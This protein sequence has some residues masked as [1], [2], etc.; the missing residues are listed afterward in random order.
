[1]GKD[2]TRPH[3]VKGKSR[4]RQDKAFRSALTWV[5]AGTG[6]VVLLLALVALGLGAAVVAARFLAPPEPYIDLTQYVE[7][8]E[9]AKTDGAEDR[10]LR[11]AVATMVSAEETFSTYRTLVER[12]G[13]DVG[14]TEAFI[15]RPSYADVREDLARGDLD[16]ALVC[17]G[18]YVHALG[19]KQLKLLVQ[20][21]FEEGLAYRCAL[22]V[23][24]GS[25]R[26]TVEDLRGSVMAFTDR[27]SN[28]G[29]LVPTALLLERGHDPKS[30]FGKVIFSGSHDR[31]ISA[32]AMGVVD[33]ASIDTLVLESKIRQDPSLLKKI[34]V[35]WQSEPLGPPPVVVRADIDQELERALLGAFLALDKD[36]EGRKILLSIGI[37]RFVPPRPESYES[38]VKMYDSIE[39]AGGVEWR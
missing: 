6:K 31:S 1:M 22:I 14:Y 8:T 28:T 17:T 9:A 39:R 37:K 25:S 38:V 29:C 4:M 21:E 20:P 13:R 11:F 26:K 7:N 34:R 19:R 2:S 24:S 23:G 35:I 36:K 30:F 18:T 16:V 15:L 27:E 3:T 12:I 32:V 10:K 5:T 33:A